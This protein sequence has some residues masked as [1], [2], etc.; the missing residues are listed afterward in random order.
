MKRPEDHH[1]E[2]RLGYSF[3]QPDLLAQALTHISALSG[4]YAAQECYQ[5]LEFVGDHV[6]GALVASKLH[7]LYPQADEGELSRRLS[8]LVRAE[9]CAEVAIA[10]GLGAHLRLH[11]SETRLGA[12]ERPALLADACEAVIAA[13]FLDG[14]FEAAHDV[15][16]RFWAQRWQAKASDHRDPKTSLQEWAQG[17][18]LPT[19]VYTEVKREG[20]AHAPVFSVMVTVQGEAPMMGK[21]TSKRLAEQAAAK[22]LLEKVVHG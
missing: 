6:L 2:E 1:L 9:T 3:R 17:R 18:G 8:F 22:S 14:G 4:A 7:A 5:R 10:M 15:V 13:V 20:P 11:P 21:G 12:R 16:E 19:P